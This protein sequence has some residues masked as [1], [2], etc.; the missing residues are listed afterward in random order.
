MKP[1]IP[2]ADA[3]AFFEQLDDPRS[4]LSLFDYLPNVSLFVKDLNHRFVKV[5]RN[6]LV[7]HGLSQESEA[8]GK[9]DLDFHPPA[10]AEQY[11][12]EDK[13]VMQSRTPIIE[14]VWLVLNHDGT[15]LWYL[16][17]KLP[18]LNKRGEV[19]G[20]A[21]FLTPHDRANQPHGS[22][23]RLGKVCNYVLKNYGS[24]ITVAS[25]AQQI[26]ISVS[27]LQR[28]FAS[29]FNM[30]P[31]DYLAKVRLSVAQHQLLHSDKSLGRIAIDCGYYDQSHFN[32]IF[33]QAMGQT[34]RDFQKHFEHPASIPEN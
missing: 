24:E 33:R 28:E 16:C 21:G 14:A 32:R 7:R 27:Q 17:T 29:H 25:M 23:D 13:K 11:V 9:C 1:D 34:P 3:T 6:F 12:A 5:N 4:I 2:K 8:L 18:M 26:D 31:R 30:S 19:I 15:P 20:L 22:Y 10:L